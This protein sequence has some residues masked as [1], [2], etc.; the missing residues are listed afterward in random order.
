[1]RTEDGCAGGTFAAVLF[2]CRG[3]QNGAG[4]V[5]VQISGIVRNHNIWREEDGFTI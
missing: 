3:E 4:I 2:P 5:P 1:M